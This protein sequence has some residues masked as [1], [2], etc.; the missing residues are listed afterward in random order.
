MVL[1]IDRRLLALAALVLA[2]HVVG[3]WA[4]IRNFLPSRGE[5]APLETPAAIKVTFRDEPRTAPTA[6]AAKQIVQ[7]DQTGREV[8]P[9]TSAFL[10][11]K[12]MA[13][14]RQTMARKVDVFNRAAKGSTAQPQVAGSDAKPTPRQ[15]P[16]P[17]L[18]NLKLSDLGA[19]H[20]P[21]PQIERRPASVAKQGIQNG[22]ERSKGVSS[23]N[24]Y[25]EH[26]AL[27]DFTQLNTVEYKYYG[28]YHRIRQKLEQF[29]GRTLKEKAEALYKSGR[30][31][32]ASDMYTTSLVI[33][34]NK[35]GEIVRV[36][37]KSSSGV[38]ELDDAAT[39]SFNE[40]GPFP[41]PPQGLL[42][43]GHATIEWGFV[44]KS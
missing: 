31:L 27:G 3:L 20:M 39:E 28:F 26:V 44:V 12:D 30:R 8:K 14:D 5:T 2:I 42:V 15:R 24:D 18:K 34:M 29:W 19:A 43:N 4:E 1:H 40:A 23:T 11:E 21:Q 41:N 35:A 36:V 10:G 37:V 16:S 25:V 38:R 13:F 9:R 32:P 17:A 33:T 7:T 6:P 22:D